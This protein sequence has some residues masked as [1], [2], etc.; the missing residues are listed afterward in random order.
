MSPVAKRGPP[1]S[2]LSTISW[3]SSLASHRPA[4]KRPL[5]ARGGQQPERIASAVRIG[6]DRPIRGPPLAAD[7]AWDRE[8]GQ[9]VRVSDGVEVGDL[10]VDDFDQEDAFQLVAAVDNHRGRA[11]AVDRLDPH[12]RHP[13]AHP[14]YAHENR[15]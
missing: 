9:L 1:T 4:D 2:V 11:V 8:G 14:E 13:R 15:G 7:G 3:R 12:V 5:W 10:A 6:S